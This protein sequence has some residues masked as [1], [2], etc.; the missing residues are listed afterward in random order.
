MFIFSLSG[1]YFLSNDYD[2]NRGFIKSKVVLIEREI[3]NGFFR[4]VDYGA[5]INFDVFLQF[6]RYLFNQEWW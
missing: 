6:K 4:K 1:N 2:P 3:Y 5:L